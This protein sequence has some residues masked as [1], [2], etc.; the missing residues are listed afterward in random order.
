MKRSSPSQEERNYTYENIAQNLK[1]A[2]VEE[3]RKAAKLKHD[4]DVYSM[5]LG[6]DEDYKGLKTSIEEYCALGHELAE[7][8]GQMNNNFQMQRTLVE[9][10]NKELGFKNRQVVVL[11]QE[12]KEK[13][14][15]ILAL[16]QEVSAL[17]RLLEVNFPEDT[18]IIRPIA[19][20]KGRSLH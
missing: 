20:V 5:Y 8:A 12:I 19:K 2:F 3:R 16:S 17:K 13:D 4:A 15:D 1:S 10:Q 7:A 6:E 14:Q 9:N 11:Q 18:K